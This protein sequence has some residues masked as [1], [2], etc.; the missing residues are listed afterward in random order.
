MKRVA[1]FSDTHGRF[2]R[3]PAALDKIEKAG[4]VEM[5][6]HLGDYGADAETIAERL[7]NVPF[8][9]VR[10]NNDYF[11]NLPRKRIVQVG[12]ALLYMVHGDAYYNLGPLI[13]EAKKERCAAA[14]FGHTHEPL[15][16][17]D[18]ELLIVNPGSLSLPRRG[19]K[20]SFALL[21]I[22]GADVNV[23]MISLE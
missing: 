1:V 8:A 17:A 9:A 3:L 6:L 18:G 12:D 15:L 4:G 5:V 23:K 2:T 22:D 10:G 21:E 11:S 20:A 7:K 13:R 14:L 16:Q 19:Y